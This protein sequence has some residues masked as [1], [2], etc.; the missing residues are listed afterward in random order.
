MFLN[1][2][3]V[4]A[5][6]VSMG[7]GPIAFAVVFLPLALWFGWRVCQV[8]RY[9]VHIHAGDGQPQKVLMTWA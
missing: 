5:R 8:F 7:Y 3:T 6:V 9:Q 4:C 2:Y 1:E